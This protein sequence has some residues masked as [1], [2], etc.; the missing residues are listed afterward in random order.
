MQIANVQDMIQYV[1]FRNKLS[2][3][4]TGG[5]HYILTIILSTLKYIGSLVWSMKS[6]EYQATVIAYLLPLL[7]KRH[8]MFFP[9]EE[10]VWDAYLTCYFRK[11]KQELCSY[12]IWRFI[13]NKGNFNPQRLEKFGW[14]FFRT[15]WLTV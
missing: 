10:N 8:I 6:E 3:G 7:P 1:S 9:A 12:D 4:G 2:G 5:G 11:I 13:F 14:V 15:E